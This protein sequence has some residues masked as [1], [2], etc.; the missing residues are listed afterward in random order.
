[1]VAALVFVL[2]GFA[3]ASTRGVFAAQ[4]DG[5]AGHAVRVVPWAFG[6]LGW[7]GLS[8]SMFERA[9]RRVQQILS[10]TVGFFAVLA[11]TLGLGATFFV[12]A[13]QLE[14]VVFRC[15]EPSKG[16]QA[17]VANHHVP[18]ICARSLTVDDDD[19]IVLMASG[20]EDL[21]AAVL[22]GVKSDDDHRVYTV[23]LSRRPEPPPL[24]P[25]QCSVTKPFI[26]GGVPMACGQRSRAV[27]WEIDLRAQTAEIV[28]GRHRLEARTRIG[29]AAIALDAGQNC[30]VEDIQK[31]LP[32]VDSFLLDPE[33]ERSAGVFKFRVTVCDSQ[34]KDERLPSL[35]ELFIYEGKDRRTELRCAS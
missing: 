4:S 33:C 9:R 12:R 2:A 17:F 31:K 7:L 14:E 25:W 35:P 26:D 21:R 1:L 34:Q 5:P 30:Y 22:E 3:F 23:R 10:S 16:V 29:S 11:I 28:H 27:T 15:D 32:E 6:F 24:Q 20:Y 8:G 13:F 18:D 19:R